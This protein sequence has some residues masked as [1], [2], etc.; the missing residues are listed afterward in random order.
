MVVLDAGNIVYKYKKDEIG[1]KLFSFLYICISQAAIGNGACQSMPEYVRV[2]QRMPEYARVCQS[3]PE[4]ARV[5]QSMPEYA[6]VCQR[7]PEYA[8]VCKS[9]PEYARVFHISSM[10]PTG[11]SPCLGCRMKAHSN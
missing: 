8:R 5:C 3:M 7:M 11:S 1:E 9:M 2:C 6:R 10:L 4:Y